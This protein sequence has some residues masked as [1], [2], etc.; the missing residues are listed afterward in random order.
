MSTGQRRGLLMVVAVVALVVAGFLLVR[1]A[2]GPP[3]LPESVLVEGVCL[4][5]KK[6][7]SGTH[8]L[9]EHEPYECGGCK[10]RAVYPWYYCYDCQRRFVPTLMRPN[11]GQAMRLPVSVTCPGCQSGNTTPFESGF[12]A[13]DQIKGDLPLP[14]WE[15]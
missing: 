5:C 4:S 15:P 8:A 13:Q 3:K 2:G 6:A 1:N 12:V 7:H 10:T 11:P 9:T 14:K